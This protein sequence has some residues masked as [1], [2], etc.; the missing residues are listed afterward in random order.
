MQDLTPAE[1]PAPGSQFS[2]STDT[3]GLH[4]DFLLR[5]PKHLVLFLTL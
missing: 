3:L 1:G 2:G 4:L 5:T